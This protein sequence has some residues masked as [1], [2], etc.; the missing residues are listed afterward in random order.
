MTNQ[1][2]RLHSAIEILTREV[3]ILKASKINYDTYPRES[4]S[5][6]RVLEELKKEIDRNL[7]NY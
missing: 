2:K 4:V 1:E 7:H 3:A 6:E 5:V